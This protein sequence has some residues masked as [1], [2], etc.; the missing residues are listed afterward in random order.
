MRV[1][2]GK[3]FSK[4]SK[5]LC[6]LLEKDIPLKF[7]EEC[8]VAFESLK[9]SLTTA[10]VITVPDSNEPFEMIC[11][12]SDFV[13]GA[14]LGQ[15]KKYIFHGFYYDSKTLND[16][17]SKWV[18]VKIFPT[19]DA[20]VV[21]NFLHKKMFTYF[22][23]PRVIIS[24]EESHFYNRKFTLLM[25]RYHVNHRVATTYHPQTNGQVEVSNRE[26]KRIL[27][28]V[29]YGKVCHLP[30][31]LEH[32]SYW[33]LKKL[34]LD[35]EAVGEKEFSN[36]MN[37]TNFFYRIIK[38]T[39]YTRKRSRDG[40]I[41]GKLKSR[42]SGPFIVKTVFSHGAVEIFDKHPYQAFKVN[43]QRLKYYYGDTANRE[44]VSAVLVTTWFQSFT[45]S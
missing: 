12:A 11:D 41:G 32:K 5:P 23:T 1:F 16:Y 18:E 29:V 13:V 9:K 24:Y 25:E 34:N 3:D 26:I 19:N 39:S 2:F 44:V 4:I 38:I 10:P 7:D 22:G 28:K 20:K 42:W 14:V 35:M 45:S 30:A 15:R 37:S 40:M 27:E 33:A 8:V 6:N 17:V 36:L 43:G 21:I 31:E